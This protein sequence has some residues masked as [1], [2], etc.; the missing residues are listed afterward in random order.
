METDQA[1]MDVYI[2]SLALHDD[3]RSTLTSTMV[4]E[5]KEPRTVVRYECTF[6][7]GEVGD[8]TLIKTYSELY[9][10]H[11]IQPNK[12]TLPVT[13]ELNAVSLANLAADQK[14]NYNLQGKLI[15]MPEIKSNKPRSRRFRS[16]R[17]SRRPCAAW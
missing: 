4:E 12:C 9:A 2:D 1:F 3:I 10:E 7:P 6:V 17:A 13:L 8:V 5:V 14:L 15:Q 11:T 16:R